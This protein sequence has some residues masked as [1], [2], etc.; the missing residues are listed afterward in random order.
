MF[1]F[2]HFGLGSESPLDG[3][4][5]PLGQVPIVRAARSS[6]FPVRDPVDRQLLQRP[7]RR[8]GRVAEPGS[9]FPRLAPLAVS[10][11][12]GEGPKVQLADG[13]RVAADAVV[14]AVP[15]PEALRLGG[16]L[17]SSSE[18]DGLVGVR[19]APGI[20]LAAALC[21]SPSLRPLRILVPRDEAS[22][23]ECAILES[24]YPASR[25]PEGLGL[26]LVRATPRY[27]SAHQGT[28]AEA[29]VKELLG[30]LEALRPG[31]E[32]AVEFTRVLRLSRMAPRFDVGR[33]REIARFLR[34]QDDRRAT[35][36]RLYFAG[37]YLVHP[38]FEGALV[39]AE[40]AADAVCE[41]LSQSV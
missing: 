16:S 5:R 1:T 21:R 11:R 31:V 29:V 37:D 23:I 39:S 2:R 6:A 9:Y 33:Y 7:V 20:T 14:L 34:V 15:A 27:A 18:R 38:S 12:A 26:A 3:L 40:R 35:G 8:L 4:Q 17:L 13:R 41:D 28:P 19:Y 25:V 30:A 36:R 32:R 24:G 10:Q 22:P